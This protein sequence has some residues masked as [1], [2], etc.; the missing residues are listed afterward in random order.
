MHTLVPAAALEATPLENAVAVLTLSA[1]AAAAANGGIQLPGA[2]TRLAVTIDGSESEDQ[3]AV[4]KVRAQ[5]V[6]QGTEIGRESL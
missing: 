2:A 3:L 4:L 1:V 6:T 5:G